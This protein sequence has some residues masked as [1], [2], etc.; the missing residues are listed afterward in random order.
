MC[1]EYL[2]ERS[3]V[4]A[5]YLDQTYPALKSSWL[6]S[7]FGETIILVGGEGEGYL[8][9]DLELGL[10]TRISCKWSAGSSSQSPCSCKLLVT[11][12]CFHSNIFS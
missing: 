12:V 4:V 2:L 3:F 5:A 10:L 9:G 8:D 7:V 11:F 1:E 6:K